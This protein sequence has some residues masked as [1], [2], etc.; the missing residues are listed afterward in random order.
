MIL[1]VSFVFSSLRRQ[2][3]KGSLRDSLNTLLLSSP[4]PKS[5]VPK[6]RPKGLGLTLKSQDYYR[7]WLLHHRLWLFHHRLWLH[8]I[9]S[10]LWLLHL[11]LWLPPL[12]P[13]LWILHHRLSSSDRSPR[14]HSVCLSVHL[15]GTKCSRALILLICGSW[16]ISSSRLQD[17]FR[18]TSR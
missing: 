6:L 13:R 12:T 5:K 17:D 16:M 4:S 15:Y 9:T 14:F 8:P 10:R 11:R 2:L 1:R 7:H 3:F 18:M